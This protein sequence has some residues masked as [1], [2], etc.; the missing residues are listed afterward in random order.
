[1]QFMKF[2][3]LLCA[4]AILVGCSEHDPELE[5]VGGSP[6]GFKL[7]AGSGGSAGASGD[8]GCLP[9][10]K[11]P[12]FPCDVEAVLKAKC[13]RCHQDPTLNG[14]PFPLL[15]WEHTQID[16]FGKPV[17]E[18]MLNVVTIDFMPYTS[19]VLDP[20]VQSLTADEKSALLDWLACPTPEEGAVCP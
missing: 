1:M 2:L 10:L 18:R 14:A 12:T 20:P 16:Y 17:Y 8:A 19:L 7:D 3:S 5:R 6:G 4:G 13:H 9:V 15:K 11:N